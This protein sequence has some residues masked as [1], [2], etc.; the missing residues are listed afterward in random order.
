MNIAGI[1]FVNRIK[2]DSPHGQRD[3]NLAQF[4]AFASLCAHLGVAAHVQ[5]VMWD[6]NCDS[7][8]IDVDER[9]EHN[10]IGGAIGYAADATLDQYVLF[11]CCWHKGSLEDEL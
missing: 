5:S 1:R 8:V 9:N 10:E 3:V 4:T 11:G 7:F 6:G 2:S